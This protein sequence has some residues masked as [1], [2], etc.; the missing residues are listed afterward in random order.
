MQPILQTSQGCDHPSAAKHAKF[1]SL[2]NICL[3]SAIHEEYTQ[4]SCILWCLPSPFT[5]LPTLVGR[6]KEGCVSS[7]R[8]VSSY[9]RLSKSPPVRDGST[10]RT[11]RHPSSLLNNDIRMNCSYLPGSLKAATDLRWPQEPCNVS[12]TPECCDVHHQKLRFQN[13]PLLCLCSLRCVHLA[14][15][16]ES[17]CCWLLFLKA[18][19]CRRYHTTHLNYF[20]NSS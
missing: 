3:K 2:F 13:Q 1:L 8:H 16:R 18:Y 11:T 20:Q 7:S 9:F 17:K 15:V 5:P 6:E 14:S 19:S 10:V 4:F 12:W